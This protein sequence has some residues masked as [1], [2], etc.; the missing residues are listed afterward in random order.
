MKKQADTG[1]TLKAEH[2]AQTL[3]LPV[4]G[5]LFQ[6]DATALASTF[7]DSISSEIWGKHAFPDTENKVEHIG[8]HRFPS[9]SNTYAL[10]QAPGA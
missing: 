1:P 5:L 6:Q 4:K 7:K 8:G 3:K 2:S 9:T 10:S